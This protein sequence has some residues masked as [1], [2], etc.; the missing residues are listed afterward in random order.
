MATKDYE[1]RFGSPPLIDDATL[2]RMMA[3][4]DA[5][6]LELLGP[7]GVRGRLC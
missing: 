6:G 7:D 1:A 3:Q 2:D 5:E 4:V